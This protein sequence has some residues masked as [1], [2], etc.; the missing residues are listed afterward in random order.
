MAYPSSKLFFL[1]IPKTAGT[2]LNAIFAQNFAPESIF[3]VYE[4]EEQQKLENLTPKESDAIA[5]IQGHI[6]IRD[7][8]ALFKNQANFSIITFLRS[9][10]E[11]VIS[12][13]AFLKTW[14]HSQLYTFLNEN[15]IS[16]QEYIE[17]DAPQLRFRGKNAMVCSLCGFSAHGDK[18]MLESAQ[19]NLVRCAM[20]G[21]TERF[22]ES[23]L[24]MQ[25]QFGLTNIFYERKNVRSA[26]QKV[27]VEKSTYECIQNHNALDIALYEFAVQKFSERIERLGSSFAKEIQLY[28]KLNGKFQK[29]CDM[30]MERDGV[31]EGNK[32]K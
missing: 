2:T 10:V 31:A 15:N 17:S 32:L 4:Y 26:A 12:E 28:E 27:T 24:L 14:P 3:S 13:Y 16:L 21:I 22:N 25:K 20:F 7:F 5:L 9:P 8:D 30:I 18:A 19:K 1:H 6:L 29:V 23:L 11:R